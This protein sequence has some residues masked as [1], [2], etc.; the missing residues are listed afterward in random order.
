MLFSKFKKLDRYDFLNDSED[1]VIF[2]D[3]ATEDGKYIDI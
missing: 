1:G 3:V 2:T